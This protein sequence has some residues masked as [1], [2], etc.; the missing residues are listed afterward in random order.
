[1]TVKPRTAI[2]VGTLLVVGAFAALNWS[3]FNQPTTLNF[4]FWQ[5]DAPLGVI[6][7]LSTAVL[8]VSFFAFLARLETLALLDSK[9]SSK[10]LEKA[11]R[12]AD[13]SEESR[14]KALSEKLDDGLDSLHE[15]LDQL[16]DLV[17]G[18]SVEKPHQTP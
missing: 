11:R 4:V 1:M 7:L 13:S 14:F 8:A 17:D 6:L 18:L 16:A 3:A 10:E 12:L 2:F 9:R 15:R 5:F